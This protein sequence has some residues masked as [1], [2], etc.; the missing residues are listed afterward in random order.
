VK[1]DGPTPSI[2]IVQPAPNAHLVTHRTAAPDDKYSSLACLVEA[3]DRM[4]RVTVKDWAVKPNGPGILVVVDGMW[5]GVVHDATKPINLEQLQPFLPFFEG[6]S[7]DS[8][9]SECGW[10]W[11]AA[12]PTTADGRMVA[13]EPAVSWFFNVAER[14]G[15]NGNADPSKPPDA[16]LIVVNWPLVGAFVLG[17]GPDGSNEATGRGGAPPAPGPPPQDGA[18]SEG[19]SRRRRT[20]SRSTTS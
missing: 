5:T 6:T 13:V 1:L 3:K 8:P 2:A 19:A 15:D 10:H 4:I 12:V 20:A 16:A 7:N 11:V 18:N 9:M 17:E 14:S